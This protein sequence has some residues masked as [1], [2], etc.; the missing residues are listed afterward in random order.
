[1][2]HGGNHSRMSD[3][4][5]VYEEAQRMGIPASSIACEVPDGSGGRTT[6]YYTTDGGALAGGITGNAEY[7]APAP[8]VRCVTTNGG[9]CNIA[10]LRKPGWSPG[11]YRWPEPASG[12]DLNMDVGE[13]NFPYLHDNGNQNTAADYKFI[14]PVII[15][16]PAVVFD[17]EGNATYSATDRMLRVLN[18]D[19]INILSERADDTIKGFDEVGDELYALENWDDSF[20]SSSRLVDDDGPVGNI[21]IEDWAARTR[22]KEQ[23][24]LLANIKEFATFNQ[25]LDP[26]Y[27]WAGRWDAKKTRDKA[28]SV[29]QGPTFNVQN[30]L[31]NN[32]LQQQ[33]F[34]LTPDQ[35]S[36]LVPTINIFKIVEKPVETGRTTV[37]P[38]AAFGY[39]DVEVQTEICEKVI[40]VPFFNNPKDEMSDEYDPMDP[41]RTDAGDRFRILNNASDF[42]RGLGGI[43]SFSWDYVGN[44]P[45]SARTDVNAKLELYFQ[46]FED[47]VRPR[48]MRVYSNMDDPDTGENH[49][50]QYIDLA[51]RS[52][53]VGNEQQVVNGRAVSPYKLRVHVGWA[54]PPD[55][56]MA[57][58][59][60][61]QSPP[62]TD[63][64][65]MAIEESFVTL[66]LTVID[67]TFDIQDDASV[68]FTIEYK[69]YI[70]STFGDPQRADILLTQ[71][72]SNRRKYRQEQLE[73]ARETCSA[74]D[75][76]EVKKKQQ[77]EI[78]IEKSLAHETIINALEHHA[79]WVNGLPGPGAGGQIGQFPYIETSARSSRIYQL[80][81]DESVYKSF[82]QEGPFVFN[83]HSADLQ[84]QLGSGGAVTS[85]SDVTTAISD[86][87][88]A[89][90]GF[91]STDI[92]TSLSKLTGF[93]GEVEDMDAARKYHLQW[94]YFGDLVHVAMER[95]EENAGLLYIPP[96]GTRGLEPEEGGGADMIYM[97][98]L[99][100]GPFD[101]VDPLTEEIFQINL[102]DVPIS[103]NYFVDW[104]MQKIISKQEATYPLMTF[105]REALNDLV[106]R[107]MND[108]ENC[109]GG[110]VR[111]KA[112]YNSTYLIAK[113]TNR[114]VEGG[115]NGLAFNSSLSKTDEP[116]DQLQKFEEYCNGMFVGRLQNGSL[117]S[118]HSGKLL[119]TG[120]PQQR[121][122]TNLVSNTNL[123]NARCNDPLLATFRADMEEIGQTICDDIYYKYAVITLSNGHMPELRGNKEDDME[124]NILWYHIGSPSGPVKNM[125]FNKTDMK[126]V[127]EARF[128]R[129]GF[130]GLAQLREPYD[131]NISVYGMPRVFP[132]QMI[133]VDPIGM[134]SGLGSP[135]DNGSIAYLLGFGGYHQIIKIKNSIKSGD[136]TTDIEAKWISTGNATD[137][138]RGT[139]IGEGTSGGTC[140]VL[141]SANLGVDNQSLDIGFDDGPWPEEDPNHGSFWEGGGPGGGSISPHDAPRGSGARGPTGSDDDEGNDSANA[142]TSQ[143]ALTGY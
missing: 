97:S 39:G 27:Q 6:V 111:Q 103:V 16:S 33:W 8:C 80:V 50:W 46:K 115:T 31:T 91:D 40:E 28:V 1:M 55:Y 13:V 19:E 44:N 75:V 106:M 21:D 98:R 69:A 68:K 76:A 60:K 57:N 120:Y 134:G 7:Q 143:M 42:G 18:E 125:K 88:A 73:L 47:I 118:H 51:L 83:E 110:S 10:D 5:A 65:I 45:V 131:V 135:S 101:V 41:A 114:G 59:E 94:F 71:D 30:I 77:E 63:E 23:C 124:R 84:A 99:V 67:H 130:N 140:G 116:V 12:P 90:G 123:I 38:A 138:R 2:A 122:Y 24:Y 102:A 32:S 54:V 3:P 86:R 17:N 49:H 9:N 53:D 14:L 20:F 35:I 56:N 29:I 133:Y 79:G 121:M 108:S 109:F 128:F 105:I 74:E 22:L 61:R 36:M 43:K 141:N 85:A 81:L 95:L 26:A 112:V 139:L 4:A 142:T 25:R 87:I 34:N 119:T 11:D 37:G 126:G 129:E 136:Y 93:E 127:K 58:Q 62:F 78:D 72:I 48:T 132:G 82:V 96:A 107:T 89:A 66:Y 117:D 104:F 64:E 137:P 92:N 100:L 113:E 70:E 15:E 52:G